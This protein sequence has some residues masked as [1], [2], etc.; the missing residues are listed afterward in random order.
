M[1]IAVTSDIP[2]PHHQDKDRA[3][4]PKERTVDICALCDGRYLALVL[5]TLVVDSEVTR[6]NTN[7]DLGPIQWQDGRVLGKYCSGHINSTF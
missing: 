4:S 7:V 1:K 5:S 6:S 3:Q 2:T